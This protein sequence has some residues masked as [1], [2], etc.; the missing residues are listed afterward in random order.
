M[1]NEVREFRRISMKRALIALLPFALLVGCSANNSQGAVN[2]KNNNNTTVSVSKGNDTT[3]SKNEKNSKEQNVSTPEPTENQST[4]V[5]KDANTTL[6]SSQTVNK[7]NEDTAATVKQTGGQSTGNKVPVGEKQVYLNKLDEI[8]KELSKQLKPLIYGVLR[9]Q[10][11]PG[12]FVQLKQEEMNWINERDAAATKAS[13]D[14]GG[15]SLS[16][17]EYGDTKMQLTKKRCYE[18]VNKYMN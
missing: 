4:D 9:K 5:S 13:A 7:T 3:S 10:L 8:D 6:N 18:L 17:V 12:E 16:G 1:K 11:S 2:P 14:A 15:G